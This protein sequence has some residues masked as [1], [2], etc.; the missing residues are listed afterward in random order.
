[1]PSK[2][3]SHGG[4]TGCKGTSHVEGPRVPPSQHRKPASL[5]TRAVWPPVEPSDVSL[6]VMTRLPRR[7]RLSNPPT[8]RGTG[9]C[10]RIKFSTKGHDLHSSSRTWTSC[11]LESYVVCHGPNSNCKN[12]IEMS[13]ALPASAAENPLRGGLRGGAS[14]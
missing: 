11:W 4:F 5:L 9:V 3:P 1:V 10:S 13:W 14:L 12:P 6:L 8:F 2:L 7:G